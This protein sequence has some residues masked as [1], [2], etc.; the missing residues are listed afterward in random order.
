MKTDFGGRNSIHRK[1]DN[2]NR[3]INLI[4]SNREIYID[5]RRSASALM[6]KPGIKP[7]T[8]QL[9]G[10]SPTYYSYTAAEVIV[11]NVVQSHANSMEIFMIADDGAHWH[12]SLFMF[13]QPL[14]GC[15][16]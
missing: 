12:L 1:Y 9:P 6:A 13:T 3:I 7:T 8:F 5:G 14:L 16:Q 2:N 10:R 15:Y 11:V 4:I